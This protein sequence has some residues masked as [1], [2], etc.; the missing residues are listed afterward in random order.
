L[1][2]FHGCALDNHDFDD[3]ASE[4]FEPFF[5]G[6]LSRPYG[7]DETA[8]KHRIEFVFRPYSPSDRSAVFRLLSILPSLYPEGDLWL[9]RR[10]QD[11]SRGKARCMIADT[12]RWGAVGLTIETPKGPHKVK[13]STIFVDPCFRGYGIGSALL[14]YCREN[15]TR[16]KLRNVYMTADLRSAGVM[17][18][19]V[20]RF[21]FELVTT[22]FNRYGRD[23]HEMVLSWLPDQK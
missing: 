6:G 14:R 8:D 1:R 2:A 3:A 20:T 15:W 18:P 19:L 23:R 16:E 4:L 17:L 13:L 7:N 5:E 9:E 22:E 21:G 11:V 10:L 12:R